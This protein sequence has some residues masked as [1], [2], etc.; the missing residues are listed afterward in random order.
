MRELA[1]A[2]RVVGLDSEASEDSLLADGTRFVPHL[3]QRA[4]PTP[5]D[6]SHIVSEARGGFPALVVA[7]RI[8]EKGREVLREAGWGWLDR[9]GH[10]RV[11]L[12]GLRVE[13]PLP[14]PDGSRR[15]KPTNAWTTVGLEIALASLL[16]PDEPV[17]ARSM[18]ARIG[19]SVGATHELIGRFTE[20]GLVGPRT[21]LP[22]VP[23]LFW[24]ASANWPDD[25]WVGLPVELEEVAD[26]TGPDQLVRVD[27]RAATLGGARIA[28]AGDFPARAYV[29][30]ASALRRARSLATSE[31]HVRSWVREAPVEWLPLN[32]DHPP[33]D[34]HPWAV[35]HPMV[36]ALR[37]ATDPARGREVVDA[38]GIVPGTQP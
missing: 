16:D 29:R 38:W 2:L 1:E 24:E 4:H 6:L 11:W 5:A 14:A 8:S 33:D 21:N 22:L 26:R 36:C 34:L 37:L 32:E 31:D 28:A 27:E 18:S 12:Q 15:S 23:D 17:T 13:A 25:A 19:R 7:D 9:R 20:L 3:V 10:V 35:A 30:S